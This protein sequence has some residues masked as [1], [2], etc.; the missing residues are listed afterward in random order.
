MTIASVLKR[1]FIW[2]L[3]S[4]SRKRRSVRKAVML[5]SLV[6]RRSFDKCNRTRILR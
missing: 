3:Q 5:R 2:R 1:G 6:R 4:C